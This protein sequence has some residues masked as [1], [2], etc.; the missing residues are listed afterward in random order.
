MAAELVTKALAARVVLVDKLIAA[1]EV[2]SIAA[3]SVDTAFRDTAPWCVV[4]PPPAL[5]NAID[6]AVY[7]TLTL[8]VA[9]R[10]PVAPVAEIV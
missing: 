8:G 5:S 2:L 9:V 10:V 7:R 3:V 6:T 4:G 1:T